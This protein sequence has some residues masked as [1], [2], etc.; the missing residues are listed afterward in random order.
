MGNLIDL[1]D[2]EDNNNFK[3]RDMVATGQNFF[4][5]EEELIPDKDFLEENKQ[6]ENENL[7]IL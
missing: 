2:N 3:N 5:N 7:N 6:S 4:S 1:S